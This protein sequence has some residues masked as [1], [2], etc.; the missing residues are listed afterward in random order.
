[1]DDPD[2]WKG[3]K[4]NDTHTHTHTHKHTPSLLISFFCSFSLSLTYLLPP[5]AHRHTHTPLSIYFYLAHTLSLYLYLTHTPSHTPT[6]LLY[7][8]H[9]KRDFWLFPSSPLA[10][11]YLKRD[12]RKFFRKQRNSIKEIC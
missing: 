11:Y 9:Y 3:I 5:P 4:K 1:M 10:F 7:F 6:I 2:L 12:R 8:H